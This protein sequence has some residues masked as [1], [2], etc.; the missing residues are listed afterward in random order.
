VRTIAQNGAPVAP[1]KAT[2]IRSFLDSAFVKV[3]PPVGVKPPNQPF[4]NFDQ[5]SKY[6]T[7]NAA[8]GLNTYKIGGGTQLIFWHHPQYAAVVFCSTLDQPVPFGQPPATPKCDPAQ[9]T[10]VA[11]LIYDYGSIRLPP[12]CYLFGS[13]ILFII[14]MLGLHWYEKDLLERQKAEAAAKLSPV[15]T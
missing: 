9:G 11:V 3:N 13:I 4:A 8:Q 6:L 12:V 15:T 1:E 7:D 2:T 5:S 14:S 10:K